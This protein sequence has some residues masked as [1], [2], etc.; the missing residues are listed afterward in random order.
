[1]TTVMTMDDIQRRVREATDYLKKE[2]KTSPDYALILGTGLGELADKAQNAQVIELCTTLFGIF[3]GNKLSL[4]LGYFAQP[5]AAADAYPVAAFQRRSG[6]TAL[7]F[8]RL[9]S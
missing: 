5:F 9:F 2:V 7:R 1:M 8:S 6:S 4:L 3:L